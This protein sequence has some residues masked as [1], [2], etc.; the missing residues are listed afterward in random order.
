MAKVDYRSIDE[1]AGKGGAADKLPFCACKCGDRTGGGEF[2]QGH[3]ARHKSNL[4]KEAL[5]DNADALAE[6]D[7]RGWT[8]FLDKARTVKAR[9]PRSHPVAVR[10]RVDDAEERARQTIE[11]IA[12]MKRAQQVKRARG[13]WSIEIGPTTYKDVL[14][15]GM[16]DILPTACPKFQDSREASYPICVTCANVPDDCDHRKGTC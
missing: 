16:P 15:L 2:R 7:R 13:L 6:L 11:R 8:R 3:D 9:P 1:Q 14:D 10:A 5:A 12:D 4:I